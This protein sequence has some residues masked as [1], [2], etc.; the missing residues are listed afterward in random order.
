MVPRREF[1]SIVAPELFHDLLVSGQFFGRHRALLKKDAFRRQ[2][3]Q[4]VHRL[5]GQAGA[6]VEQQSVQVGPVQEFQE[7]L[8]AGQVRIGELLPV[9]GPEGQVLRD[10]RIRQVLVLVEKFDIVDE[11]FAEFF[12]KLPADPDDGS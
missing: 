11:P 10:T 4:D 2:V 6:E 1:L 8:V 12:L 3:A 7:I 9:G 5:P